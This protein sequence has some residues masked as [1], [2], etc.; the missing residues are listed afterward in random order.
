MVHTVHSLVIQ[1]ALEVN[2]RKVTAPV[3]AHALAVI[4]DT[5]VIMLAINALPL[6]K[7]LLEIVMVNVKSGIT[8]SVAR[9]PAQLGALEIC[10][11]RISENVLVH[12]LQGFTVNIAVFHVKA[13]VHLEPAL[14]TLERV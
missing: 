13:G 4:M 6:V 1:A 2:V 7:R 3:S 10:V 11:R 14:R 12:A 9:H 8:E 5:S